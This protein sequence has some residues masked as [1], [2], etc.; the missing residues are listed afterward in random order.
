MSNALSSGEYVVAAGRAAPPVATTSAL[1][2][3]VSLNDWVLIATLV[4]TVL[5]ILLLIRKFIK[6]RKNGR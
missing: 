2:S 5:Q 6:E 1:L 3:G 4:Y